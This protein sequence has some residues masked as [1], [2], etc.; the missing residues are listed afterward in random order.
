MHDT[1][2]E[3]PDY[4]AE[5]TSASGDKKFPKTVRY[6]ELC[7]RAPDGGSLPELAKGEGY[8]VVKYKT[9]GYRDPVEED[10]EASVDL[11]ILGIEPISDEEGKSLAG[12]EIDVAESAEPLKKGFRKSM[13]KLSKK[14]DAVVV[15]KDT[16]GEE[17]EEFP[18]K[19]GVG[20]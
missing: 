1:G 12:A 7:L 18:T 17:D 14:A 19:E 9:V 3:V 13:E 16:E 8:A 20:Y 2:Y 10:R 15:I 11:A 5:P 6:P 4:S